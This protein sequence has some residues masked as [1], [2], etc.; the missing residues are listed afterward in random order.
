MNGGFSMQVAVHVYIPMISGY[1]KQA[2]INAAGMGLKVAVSAE[3][4]VQIRNSL[5]KAIYTSGYF[6]EYAEIY[7]Y[8]IIMILLV[9]AIT[10]IPGLILNKG[11][12]RWKKR[13]E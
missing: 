3:Y 4:L 9:L 6:S 1:L 10:G 5:G 8:A 7:A 11:T 2:F 13:G 12:R